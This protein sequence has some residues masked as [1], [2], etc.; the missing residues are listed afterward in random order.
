MNKSTIIRTEPKKTFSAICGL[1]YSYCIHT[2]KKNYK[3]QN[4]GRVSEIKI[5]NGIRLQ[6]IKQ[7]KEQ[8]FK[9]NLARKCKIFY[10]STK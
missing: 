2:P 10:E 1:R 7:E 9:K 4:T 5:E 6:E 3:L 8:L